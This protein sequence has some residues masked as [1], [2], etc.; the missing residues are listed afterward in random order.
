VQHAAEE[1]GSVKS[2]MK[3]LIKKSPLTASNECKNVLVRSVAL[4]SFL[5]QNGNGIGY[6]FTK[7]SLLV[8]PTKNN[9]MHSFS[10]VKGKMNDFFIKEPVGGPPK[11]D[12]YNNY[13]TFQACRRKGFDRTEFRITKLFMN[14]ESMEHPI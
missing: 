11:Y 5:K 9:Y 14:D 4:Y 12:F 3:R 8:R 7:I 2:S 6:L 10:A 13:R 1:E